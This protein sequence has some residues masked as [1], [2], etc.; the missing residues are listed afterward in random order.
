VAPSGAEQH[1]DG[2][3]GYR[4]R[5]LIEPGPSV[6]TAELEDDYHRMVVSL[7]H[8][9]GIIT[10][11]ES[12]MKRSPWTTCPG[13]IAQLEATFLGKNLE[14]T[15][16]RHEKTHNCT[17]LFDLATFAVAHAG[18]LASITYEIEVSDPVDGAVSA[19]LWRNGEKMLDWSYRDG[20][21]TAPVELEGLSFNDLGRWIALQAAELQESARILRWAALVAHG[22]KLD[23]PSGMPAT[24]FASGACFTFQS[25]TAKVGMRRPNA[26][27]DFSAL[28]APPMV[29]RDDMFKRQTVTHGQPI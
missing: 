1:K 3:S 5:I 19:K 23:L 21:F 2:S 20:L 26:D 10:A 29:D 8:A 4:R 6:V 17:H 25:D 13:A 12:S 7:T 22:R 15:S 9:G 18:E 14:D 27:V 16:V 28:G 24:R 11:V